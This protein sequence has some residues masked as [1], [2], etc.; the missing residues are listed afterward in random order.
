VESATS[1]LYSHASPPRVKLH[2]TGLGRTECVYPR[3]L[4]DKPPGDKR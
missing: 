1:M 3:G 4:T 2:Y